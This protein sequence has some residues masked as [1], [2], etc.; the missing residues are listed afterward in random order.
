MVPPVEI[1]SAAFAD[2]APSKPERLALNREGALLLEV[3]RVK[4]AGGDQKPN[5]TQQTN[6]HPPDPALGAGFE[7]VPT[8][9]EDEGVLIALPYVSRKNNSDFF[10]ILPSELGTR[11]PF[12]VFVSSMGPYRFPTDTKEV[13][14]DPELTEMLQEQGISLGALFG[15]LT[16]KA[17]RISPR[18]FWEKLQELGER[19]VHDGRLANE[20]TTLALLDATS[21]LTSSEVAVQKTKFWL[22]SSLSSFNPYP[23]ANGM[24]QLPDG[25]GQ[26]T[27]RKSSLTSTGKLFYVYGD[28]TRELSAGDTLRAIFSCAEW[29]NDVMYLS[30]DGNRIAIQPSDLFSGLSR[31]QENAM[32]WNLRPGQTIT[33]TIPSRAHGHWTADIAVDGQTPSWGKS[34]PRR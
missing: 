25:T 6:L 16:T 34:Q 4:D 22:W 10:L 23:S 14:V 1:T 30:S 27:S 11:T 20:Y 5:P 26:E 28:E 13:P 9:T 18:D 15:N 12:Q 31:Q 19:T 29:E 8:G 21:A 3:A 7:L 33:I 2:A 17:Q 32:R 24:G